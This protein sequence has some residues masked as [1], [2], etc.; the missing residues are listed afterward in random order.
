MILRDWP[1]VNDRKG[2]KPVMQADLGVILHELVPGFEVS[3]SDLF[4]ADLHLL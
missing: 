4:L 1:S 3:Q 2:A